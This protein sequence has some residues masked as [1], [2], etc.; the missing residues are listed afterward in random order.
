MQLVKTDELTSPEQRALVVRHLEF[1]LK[2]FTKYPD[3]S[4]K[5]ARC[6]RRLTR[7]RG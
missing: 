1:L 6:W 5:V 4:W 7:T 2:S 3:F